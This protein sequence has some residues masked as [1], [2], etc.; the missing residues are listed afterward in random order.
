[1]ALSLQQQLGDYQAAEREAAEAEGQAKRKEEKK[2][3]AGAALREQ[4][5]QAQVQLNQQ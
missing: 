4:L 3:E 2:E 1:M 5:V